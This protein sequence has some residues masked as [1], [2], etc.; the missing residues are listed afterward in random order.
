MAGHREYRSQNGPG[1]N[2]GNIF[3]RPAIQVPQFRHRPPD[4]QSKTPFCPT[5]ASARVAMVLRSVAVGAIGGARKMQR[6]QGK[7]RRH[8]VEDAG[9]SCRRPTKIARETPREPTIR[10]DVSPILRRR[11]M[12]GLPAREKKLCIHCSAGQHVKRVHFCRLPKA[13]KNSPPLIAR[14]RDEGGTVARAAHCKGRREVLSW[15]AA[16]LHSPKPSVAR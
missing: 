14:P 16:R 9:D 11:S 8:A 4:R 3:L 2:A 15:R 5:A 12:S 13:Q 7:M 6:A 10:S 1:Q